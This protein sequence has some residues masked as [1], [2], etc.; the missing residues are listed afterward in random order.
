MMRV[1]AL[2]TP[3]DLF[4]KTFPKRQLLEEVWRGSKACLYEPK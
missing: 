1:I 2:I 3:T 4:Q